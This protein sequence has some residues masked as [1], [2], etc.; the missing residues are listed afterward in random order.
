MNLTEPPIDPAELATAIAAMKTTAN[1]FYAAAVHIHVHPFIEFT[2][3]MNEYIKICERAAAIGI[4]F[5]DTSVHTGKPL[6]MHDYEAAYIG[7]KLGCIFSSTLA[8]NPILRDAF[9]S[10]AGLSP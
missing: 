6:P 5:R 8:E 3:L 7:E 10:A 1:R 4:D 9:L 2:G